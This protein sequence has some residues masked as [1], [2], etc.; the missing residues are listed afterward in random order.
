MKANRPKTIEI[1]RRSLKK[2]HR[3]EHRFRN[4]GR[5]A[6]FVGLAF[7]T[8]M[9][10]N[11]V[12]TGYPAFWQTYARLPVFFAPEII[13]PEGKGSP[14][15]LSSADYN[16][17]VKASMTSLFPGVTGRRKPVARHNIGPM[18]AGQAGSSSRIV[19]IVELS[20]PASA[21]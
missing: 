13:D 20:E 17:L 4:Y 15:A 16:A 7:L 8:L 3:A 18:N 19:G 5:G 9:F 12:L 2:R 21:R 6:I 1:V 11:I 10:V 14:Q